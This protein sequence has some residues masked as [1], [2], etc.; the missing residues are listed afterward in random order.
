MKPITVKEILNVTDGELLAGNEDIVICGATTNS[1]QIKENDLF[2][3]IIGERVDGHLFIE[4]A[5]KD[6][7]SVSFTS[8]HNKEALESLSIGEDKALIKVDDTLKA[9]QALA[10]YSRSR[11]DIPLVGITGSVG[12]TTTKEMVAQAVMSEKNVL[13]TE[14][15]LNSQ[16]GLSLMMHRLE[17]EHE[18]AV[19]EMGISEI[20]EMEKLVNIAK[21]TF[22]VMTNIGMSHINQF[23]KKETTR[24]EKLR[25]ADTIDENGA[26]FINADDELLY[27]IKEYKEGKKA[28]DI[29]DSTK[30]ALEKC[31]VITFGTRPDSDY[32]AVDIEHDDNAVTFTML[33][34]DVSM[35]VRLNVPGGH[36]VINALAAIAVADRLGIAYE[37]AI[38]YLA[39]YRPIAM[40]GTV[41]DNGN[42]RIID[43]TYNASPDSMKS[44]IDVLVNM[45]DSTRKI[46]VLADILEL[47]E[48]SQ[49]CH[50][51]VGVYLSGK[52]V[53]E[54]VTIGEQAK[55]IAAAVKERNSDIV[56]NSFDNNLDA[57]T[58]LKQTVAK[59][60]VLLVKG[61]RGMHTDEIVNAL[62]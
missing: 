8:K 48:V 4:N 31:D 17:S 61:S 60:S 45:K 36:N 54:L 52:P 62:K 5:L 18:V 20:G 46:A 19:I 6:G 59:G 35:K 14:G 21:P 15:N 1:R 44:G 9:F 50:Y 42:Y 51:D 11:F 32:R 30:E 24:K 47:G 27:E 55:A 28:I 2:V 7:A 10:K 29:Y 26:L 25:I 56:A 43:D 39:D 49:D 13:K 33:H 3:P 53:N 22:A 34:E 40:R 37:A 41:I 16:I 12:K 23:K 58:Y 57:I 38:N